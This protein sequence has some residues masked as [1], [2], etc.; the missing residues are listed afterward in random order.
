MFLSPQALQGIVDGRVEL[1]F[2]CWARPRV[3]VGTKLRTSAGLVEVLA[4][5]VVTVDQITD[6]EALLAGSSSREELVGEI[7]GWASKGPV[8]RV[9]LGFAGPDPRIELRNRCDLS[10]EELAGLKAHL[11]R[12]DRSAQGPWVRT[13]LENIGSS[14]GIRAA[15]LAARLGR[16][17]LPFKRDV[18]KLKELGLTESLEVGY[19][20]SPRGSAYL[21]ATE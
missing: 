9:R 7:S 18:R 1:T 20:L 16:E 13:V 11:A 21:A 4:V 2:R 3:R 5:D 8:H 12:M 17:T 14:P 15:E 10:A 19:R 6:E